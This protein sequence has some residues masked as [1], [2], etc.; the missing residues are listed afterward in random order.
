MKSQFDRSTL[1][2]I[3]NLLTYGRIAVIPLIIVLMLLQS[4]EYSFRANRLLCISSA[5]LFILAAISDLVDGY[6]ARRLKQVSLMGKFFDPI[7]DKLV[8]MTAIVMLIPLGRM[9][10]WFA[11]ILLFREFLISGLRSVAAGEGLIIAAGG[12][13]KKKTVWFNVGLSG[14]LL[15]YPTFG[16]DVYKGGWICIGIGLA[17]S[18]YSAVEYFMLFVREVRKGEK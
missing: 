2:S 7:A 12:S 5:I 1:L 17:Y 14:L 8:H 9:P 4:S 6:F 13:G 3:P 18:L 16:V 15:Y 10:A 11:V